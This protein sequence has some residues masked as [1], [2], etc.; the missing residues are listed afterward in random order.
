[1]TRVNANRSGTDWEKELEEI[2]S[3]RESKK[4]AH[5]LKKN[6][7]EIPLMIKAM[8]N[9]VTT[10]AWRAGWVLDHLERLNKKALLPYLNQLSEILL[11]TPHHGVQRHITRIFCN[12]PAAELEDGRLVDACFNWLLNPRTPVAVKVNAMEI[13]GNLCVR[14][15]ELGQEL[16]TVIQEGYETGTAAFKSRARRILARLESQKTTFL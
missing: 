2:R 15:P 3:G 6:P 14:Y 9:P 13:I 12:A 7:E 10:I 5:C 11:H 16:K 8:E 4:L 1:M